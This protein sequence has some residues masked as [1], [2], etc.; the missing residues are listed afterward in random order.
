MT[1]ILVGF[2]NLMLLIVMFLGLTCFVSFVHADEKN[3]WKA[4]QTSLFSGSYIYNYKIELP[5]GTH[6]LTPQ[7][8]ISYNSFLSA[9]SRPMRMV[10]SPCFLTGRDTT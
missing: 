8:S 3:V 10:P 2:K 6:G 1:N 5:P 4:Y 7:L 9:I